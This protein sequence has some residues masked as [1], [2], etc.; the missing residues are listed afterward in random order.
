MEIYKCK[1]AAQIKR[2]S[3]V[4]ESFESSLVGTRNQIMLQSGFVSCF[5]LVCVL[6]SVCC[7]GLFI[8]VQ[9]ICVPV[10]WSHSCF[11]LVD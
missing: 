7:V 5:S 3:Q 9:Y 1:G 2:R 10:C 8:C 11:R 4:R 6:V